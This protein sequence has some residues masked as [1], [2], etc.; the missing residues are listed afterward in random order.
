MTEDYYSHARAEILPL[1]VRP[2]SRV[3]ELGCGAGA[4]I[5]MLRDR[6]LCRW[7]A[8]IEAHGPAAERARPHLDLLI[9]GDADRTMPDIE[10]GSLDVLL[11]LDVLE[12]L[13]DP[14]GTLSRLAPL[15]KPDGALIA[16]IPNLRFYP[17]TLPLILRGSWTY[18]DEGIMDRTHL[19][20]FTWETIEGLMDSAG[21]TVDAVIRSGL[22]GK[23]S[24]ILNALT[25]GCLRD[26]FV[27]RYLFRA[28]P[29]GAET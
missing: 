9:S 18:R 8:G 28:R 24:R 17:V 1:W 13:V 21:L 2:Q 26:L 19:R 22:E 20:F 7:A 3:L 6:G 10:P 29:P 4:T 11:C 27:Y 25:F 23:R 5:R 16:S 14:W 12:H 15:L